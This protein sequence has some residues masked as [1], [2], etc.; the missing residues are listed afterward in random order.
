LLVVIALRLFTP[1]VMAGT[2]ALA[3]IS[4]SNDFPHAQQVYTDLNSAWTEKYLLA[5]WYRWDTAHYL[6]K[7]DPSTQNLA[8]GEILSY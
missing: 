5:P 2:A 3:P 6:D 8:S 4:N 7:A 1:A